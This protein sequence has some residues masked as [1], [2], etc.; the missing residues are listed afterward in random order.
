MTL[1]DSSLPG[2]K[3]VILAG[4]ACT[5]L[6]FFFSP[7]PHP[8]SKET[9]PSVTCSPKLLFYRNQN[10]APQSAADRARE[11]SACMHSFIQQQQQHQ[12]QLAPTL[13]RELLW[14]LA[15]TQVL[16]SANLF[17]PMEEE[18]AVA[19]TQ[20]VAEEAVAAI[21][22]AVFSFGLVSV[23]LCKNPAHGTTRDT[24]TKRELPRY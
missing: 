8:T 12:H 5:S 20:R 3:L 22:A 6:G 4:G 16:C 21:M 14:K 24:R 2:C 10:A 19:T 7:P 23:C 1:L 18:E 15:C 9:H 11:A 17:D 13:A